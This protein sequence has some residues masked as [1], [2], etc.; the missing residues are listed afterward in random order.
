M[1]TTDQKGNVAELTIAR[2]AIEVGVDVYRPVGE[3]TRHD[4]IFEVGRTLWRVQCKWA[5]LYRNVIGLRCYSSRRNRDGLQ[6]R[7]YL[8]GEVDAYAAYC[9]DND[10][11]YFVPFA[12][13]GVRTQISLRLARCR[14]NQRAGIH[15]AKDYEFAATLAAQGAVAQLGER[16]S[17]RLEATGSSPVGSTHLHLLR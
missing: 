8:A 5:P 16:Q 9:P 10:R 14:N 13:F 3:G 2:A 4:M 1:L 15:W 17:G 12:A 11:C 6:R 7:L